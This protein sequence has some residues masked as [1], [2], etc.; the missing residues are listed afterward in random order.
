MSYYGFRPYVPVAKRRAIAARELEKLRKKGRKISPVVLEGRPIARTFWGKAWCE[1]LERYSDFENRLPRGRTYVRNGSVV[2][3]QIERGQV[4][5]MVCGSELYTVRIDIDTIPK[6]RWE[7]ICRDCLGSVT[8]LVELLQGKISKNVM[9]RVCREGD[10]LFPSPREI[11]MRC[12]CPD[13]ADMC[14]HASAV[15]YGVGARF[16]AE[17]DFLFALRGVD[18]SELIAGAGK[19]LPIAQT[20]VAAE[21]VIADN[22]VAELFGIELEPAPSQPASDDADAGLKSELGDDAK[23]ATP[24]NRQPAT[25]PVSLNRNSAKIKPT[26]IRSRN[27]KASSVSSGARPQPTEAGANS[28]EARIARGKAKSATQPIRSPTKAPKQEVAA[29]EPI[30]PPLERKSRRGAQMIA[31]KWTKPK[32]QKARYS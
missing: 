32:K 28:A 16:D 15:L 20:Q 25:G 18:R 2:D 13:W 17:P 11:K 12:S 23:Q 19:N 26:P 9:E 4:R 21:R 29:N 1:N 10:G 7:A 6:A 31:T 24:I 5:A 3:L 14:K 8:S 27:A 30:A 22:D